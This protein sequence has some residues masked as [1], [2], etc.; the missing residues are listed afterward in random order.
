MQ[1]HYVKSARV[2]SFCGLYF[3]EFG[4]YKERYPVFSPNAGKK[5]TPNTNTFFAMKCNIKH[6]FPFNSSIHNVEKSPTLRKTPYFH[7]ISWC[8]H[9][10]ERHSFRI[11]SG[12]L[13]ETLRKLCLSI[14]FSHQEITV[15]YAVRTYL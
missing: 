6:F 13:P 8:G 15:F 1:T 11:I 4:L 7:L 5:K 10:V 12:E 2:R 14:K 3:P 9:F